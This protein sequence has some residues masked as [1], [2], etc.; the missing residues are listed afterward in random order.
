MRKRTISFVVIS[1]VTILLIKVLPSSNMHLDDFSKRAK[2]SLREVGNQLL[3][4]NQDSSSLVLPIKRTGDLQYAISFQKE[5]SIV[6]DSLV[7]I[8]KESLP[9]V[10]FPQNYQVEVLRCF[11]DEVA[12]SYEVHEEKEKTIIPCM[13]RVLPRACYTV[14]VQFLQ[15]AGSFQNRWIVLIAAFIS[16]IF[17]EIFWKQR[18]SKKQKKRESPSFTSLGSFRFYPDQNK[19]IKEAEEIA[20]SK[21]ECELLEIF[22]SNPNQVLKREDLTKRVWED[23]GVFVGRSLDTYISKLRKKLQDDDSIKITNV[24]GVGYKLEIT[25]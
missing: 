14:E 19:L 24:H 4:S 17:L 16:L 21:K 18:A 8:V 20:L 5:L 1:V 25:D 22:V 23:N 13:N 11:D 9:S 12:Y 3:L 2:I 15:E 7:T 10:F 6:P